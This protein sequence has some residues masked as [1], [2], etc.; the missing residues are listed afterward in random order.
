[1]TFSESRRN[2]ENWHFETL[3][4]QLMDRSGGGGEPLAALSDP[5]LDLLQG[6]VRDR[7]DEP[8]G[9]LVPRVGIDASE[10][11]NSTIFP[12][13][14]TAIMSAMNLTTLRSWLMKM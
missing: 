1:V 14:I 9:V 13:F 8:P 5:F 7:G 3:V 2:R 6:I 10:G 11:P 4:A 12:P